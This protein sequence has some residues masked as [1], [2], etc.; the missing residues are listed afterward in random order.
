MACKRSR[1]QSPPA[2]QKFSDNENFRGYLSD[3]RATTSCAGSETIHT[4]IFMPTKPGILFFGLTE[5]FIGSATL[6]SI[7]D[8]YIAIGATKPLNVLIF[9]VVSSFISIA[10]GIGL[11]RKIRL[12][13]KLLVF[14]AG[15]VILSKALIMGNIISLCCALETPIPSTAKNAISIAYHLILIIFLRQPT[16]KKE[17]MR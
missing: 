1:V 11:L 13:R 15:W 6:A 17:L 12:A 8:T 14:F 9:V 7:V 5:I 10:L 3:R 2:P 16:V 4:L